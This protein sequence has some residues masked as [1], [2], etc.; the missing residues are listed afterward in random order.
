MTP[1]QL[2]EAWQSSAGLAPRWCLASVL[3]TQGSVPRKANALM[4]IGIQADGK[5]IGIGSIG[6]GASEAHVISQARQL[7][8]NEAAAPIRVS[9]SLNDN[10]GAN[11]Q[12]FNLDVLPRQNN[13]GVC[14]GQMQL[15]LACF[16]SAQLQTAMAAIATQLRVGWPM[17][18][19]A[20]NLSTREH[21]STDQPL[22]CLLPRAR[23][24]IG[25][26]GHCGVALARVLIDL[27]FPVAVVDSR[28]AVFGL[29]LD[30]RASRFADWPA[31]LRSDFRS[32]QI[33][34]LL[35]RNMNE[36]LAALVALQNSY[37]ANQ[38]DF[39]FVGMM[40]SRRRVKMVLQAKNWNPDFIKKLMAPVGI[41]IGA[42]APNEI[43][44]A[45]AAQV[46]QVQATLS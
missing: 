31:A 30:N 41:E 46:L 14:G 10:P 42:E 1:L 35:S 5:A 7:L 20:E 25:G 38:C 4:L 34:L 44:I 17:W 32:S 33:A 26:A 21:E 3:Q 45:I 23:C 9:I 36:D 24:L 6:G 15:C 13:F 18:I 19:H 43:A 29:P 37:E 2:F 16:E 11:L 28:D 22:I 39:A 12:K 8:A 40:G 27:G